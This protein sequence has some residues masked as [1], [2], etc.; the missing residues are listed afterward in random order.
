MYPTTVVSATT[1]TG[2]QRTYYK[3]DA[4]FWDS[5]GLIK[6]TTY[7]TTYP[8]SSWRRLRLC[9]FCRRR[10]SHQWFARTAFGF[11]DGAMLPLKQWDSSRPVAKS[12]VRGPGRSWSG[13][14][15]WR[16]YY[17]GSCFSVILSSYVRQSISFLTGSWRWPRTA[18]RGRGHFETA[19]QEIRKKKSRKCNRN[20]T[21]GRRRRGYHRS[22]SH[23][24]FGDNDNVYRLR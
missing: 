2:P 10:V 8:R 6:R 20:R 23:V 24:V 22:F 17:C 4:Q 21:S 13:S 7:R 15:P 14:F 5:L 1:L 18:S 16:Q 19:H 9:P 11:S 12:D 3:D